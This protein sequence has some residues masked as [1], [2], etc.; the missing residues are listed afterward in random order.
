MRAQD[1]AGRHGERTVCDI[2][3]FDQPAFEYSRSYGHDVRPFWAACSNAAW[4]LFAAQVLGVHRRLLVR[5]ASDMARLAL[6]GHP[7][8]SNLLAAL[9][10]AESC[11]N[12]QRIRRDW[13]AAAS[14]SAWAIA[15]TAGERGAMRRAA[16][17][18]AVAWVVDGAGSASNSFDASK[19]VE[20]VLDAQPRSLHGD[21]QVTCLRLV[22]ARISGAVIAARYRD[23][24]KRSKAQRRKSRPPR[25]SHRR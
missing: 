7:P 21:L 19:L 11:G 12:G 2:F 6:N 16:G 8:N 13:L 15:R 18:M 17:A 9:D 23:W 24:R 20:L 25:S 1:R 22:R 10:G 5:V 3:D 14:A 4:L